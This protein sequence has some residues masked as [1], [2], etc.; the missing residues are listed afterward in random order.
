MGSDPETHPLPISVSSVVPKIK[1]DIDAGR[2]SSIGL[3][4][5]N[6]VW[7]IDIAAKI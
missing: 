1:A 4:A 7:P 3:V 2:P 6:W 5:G